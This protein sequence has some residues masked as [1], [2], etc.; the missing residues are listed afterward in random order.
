M[1][2]H[3]SVTGAGLQSWAHCKGHSEI[4]WVLSPNLRHA[5]E[6]MWPSSCGPRKVGLLR[7]LTP[8]SSAPASAWLIGSLP[9]QPQA[10]CR[11]A[12]PAGG[13]GG[14]SLQEKTEEEG[15]SGQVLLMLLSWLNSAISSS[16]LVFWR[17]SGAVCGL[18]LPRPSGWE[19]P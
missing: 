2:S 3:P 10:T 17:S 6:Q 13:E 11:G 4:P 16:L 19:R 1:T 5:G 8:S 7:T 18:I 12:A 14:K 9:S 15:L